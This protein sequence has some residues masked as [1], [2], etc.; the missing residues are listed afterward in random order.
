MIIQQKEKK[1]FSFSNIITILLVVFA[2]SMFVFPEVKATVLQGLMKT[3]FFSPSINASEHKNN[4]A[5]Q[6]WNVQFINS[7]GEMIDGNALKGKVVFIN[8]WA[9]WCPPCIAEMPSVQQFY[10][11]FKDNSNIIFLLVDADNN[12]NRSEKFMSKKGYNLPVYVAPEGLP[13]EWF[14]GSLPTTLILDKKGNIIF[15]HKGMANY[16]DSNF[17]NS[18]ENLL[19]ESM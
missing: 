12:L 3:G 16:N 5:E 14:S 2:I 15:H 19:K 13:D 4:E 9:T 7:K 8:I 1:I 17:K 10:N 11:N 18:I 6:N